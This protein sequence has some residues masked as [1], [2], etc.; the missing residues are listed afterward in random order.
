MTEPEFETEARGALSILRINRPEKRNAMNRA[1]MAGIGNGMAAA[2]ESA[3][4]R[5]VILTGAGDNTFCAG[6]DLAAFASG[7]IDGDAE[8]DTGM[9]NFAEFVQGRIST[10][11][12]C[13]ANGHAVAGG[14]ELLL[15]CDLVVAA[16]HAKFGLPEVKRGLFAAGGGVFLSRRVALAKALEMALTGDPITADEALHLGLVNRVVPPAEVMSAALE[17]AERVAANGPLAVNAT[18]RL[19]RTAATEPAADVHAL[20]QT[21]QPQIFESEDAKEGAMAFVEKRTPQWKGR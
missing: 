11:I 20:Q 9:A 12:I 13:A 18:K 3:D 19:V 7:Q 4:I 2:D 1:V 6:M 16:D 14:F 17:L 15:A 8:Q 10:P 5:A 21:L